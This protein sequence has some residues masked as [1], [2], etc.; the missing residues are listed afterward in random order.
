MD[1]DITRN[2]IEEV[3]DERRRQVEEEGFT[4]EK[5]DAH[6]DGDLARAGAAYAMAGLSVGI[7]GGLWPWLASWFK[8]G[9]RRRN[10]IK[11]LALL[12]AEVEKMD[13]A[14]GK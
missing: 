1:A 12:V 14:S 6:N 9:D 5:D 2:V 4:P 10:L 11:A 13:R 3:A 7:A 8:P